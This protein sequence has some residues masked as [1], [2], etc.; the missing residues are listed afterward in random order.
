MNTKSLKQL[1]SGTHG[2]LSLL[3]KESGFSKTDFH[4]YLTSHRETRSQ[5]GLLLRW[6][7]D[8]S[9]INCVSASPACWQGWGRQERLQETGHHST[10]FLHE[11]NLVAGVP[12]NRL[13]TRARL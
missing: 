11:A 7:I 3:R 13:Q 8:S 4:V 9:V 10:A 1:L 12:Y 5:A 6:V 2:D